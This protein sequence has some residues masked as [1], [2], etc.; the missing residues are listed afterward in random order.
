MEAE[1]L[2]F[3]VME[4]GGRWVFPFVTSSE[5]GLAHRPSG[6]EHVGLS[7]TMELQVEGKDQSEPADLSCP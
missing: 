6:Q 2:F 1:N 5:P 3:C 4:E 7:Q